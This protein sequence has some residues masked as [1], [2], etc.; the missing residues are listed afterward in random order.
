MDVGNPA[1]AGHFTT[2]QVRGGAVQGLDLHL[3]RLRDATLE[4]FGVALEE[5][6]LRL[7]LREALAADAGADAERACTLRVLVRGAAARDAACAT[8]EAGIGAGVVDVSI[9]LEP[10]RDPGTAPLRLRSFRVLRES[11]RLKHLVLGPQFE[12]RRAAQAA[13][14]DDALLVDAEGFIAE[15]TFWNVAFWDGAAVTWPDAPCL[16][17]V[18]R[19]LL[20]AALAARDVPQ[21]RRPLPLE[22]LPGMRAAFALNSRGVQEI[23]QVDSCS[24]AGDAR[25]GAELRALLAG[26]V[27][28]RF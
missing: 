15:G 25:F 18:T 28:Q 4:M 27:W 2:M 22:A 8:G 7:R 20:Q 12:A 5:G 19:R 26:C 13:G 6:A 23:G 1:A 11:P 3:A 21:R 24:F 17:G 14:F 16:D 10:P 9:E